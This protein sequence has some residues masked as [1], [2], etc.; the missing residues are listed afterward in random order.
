M[1]INK[2][3]EYNLQND[4]MY[5]FLNSFNSIVKESD[6]FLYKNVAKKIISTLRLNKELLLTFDNF[7]NNF[8][9][10]THSLIKNSNI[11]SSELSDESIVLLS[12]SSL[13]IIYLEKNNNKSS[14]EEFKLKKDSKSML[15]E[16]KMKGFGNN[17]VKKIILCIKVIKNMFLILNKH[18]DKKISNIADILLNSI[19]ISMLNS[20][21]YIINK[22]NLNI[23]TFVQNFHTLS[24]D[25]KTHIGKNGIN[26]II[27][28]LKKDNDE[29]NIYSP[30]K[31]FSTFCE[32]IKEEI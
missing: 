16:L 2:F 31:N 29:L 27:D 25:I 20:I 26:D 5:D 14:E 4:L 18:M 8:Y 23:D 11:S 10:I 15:E 24:S 13:T 9:P 17:I 32:L 6:Q 22:Y 3:S 7:L 12:L 28:K 21:H 1:K 19:F 30:V